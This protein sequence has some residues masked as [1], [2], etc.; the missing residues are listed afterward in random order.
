MSVSYRRLPMLSS[1]V[2]SAAR[3]GPVPSLGRSWSGAARLTDSGCAEVLVFSLRE[4]SFALPASHVVDVMPLAGDRWTRLAKMAEV[5]TLGASGLPLIRL[6]ARLGFDPS[7]PEQGALVLFGEDG[8]VRATLLVDD[9]PRRVSADVK[10]MPEVWRE[11]FQP[12]EDL[13]G[14][15]ARLADG[16]QAALIDLP[17]GVVAARPRLPSSCERDSAHLLVR[18]GRTEMEAVRVAALRG[19]SRIDGAR[20]LLMLGGEG[21]ALAVDE[22]VGLAPRGRVERLGGARMLVTDSGRYRLLEPG[23]TIPTAA[24]ASRVLLTAPAGEGRTRL[25]DLVRSMGHDV[26]IADD[27]RAARLVGGRFDILL[28]DLDA[29]AGSLIASEPLPGGARRI[30]FHQ[31]GSIAN[32]AGFD[33]VVPVDNPVAL[34]AALIAQ[35]P[36]AA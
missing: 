16:T 15:V 19:M 23:E 7:R 11:E 14:G 31:P 28:F 9:L 2:S 32:P 13:I 18:A 6:A 20:M 1:D 3:R 4:M 24:A 29:Y 12:C 10:V 30:G 25:R 35:R 17:I 36:K 21:E 26:S 27:P 33:A 22:V 5:G 8:K 34:I